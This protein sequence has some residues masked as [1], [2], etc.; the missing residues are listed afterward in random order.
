M[1]QATKPFETCFGQGQ[2]KMT[3]EAEGEYTYSNILINI[4]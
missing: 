3:T 2:D 1:L 4:K